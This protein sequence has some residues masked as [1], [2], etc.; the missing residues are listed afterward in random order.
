M[1]I[2]KRDDVKWKVMFWRV[3][4]EKY[5]E[6]CVVVEELGKYGKLKR[7]RNGVVLFEVGYVDYY[8]INFCFVEILVF[9]DCGLEISMY[10][11]V[12]KLFGD[13]R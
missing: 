10:L 7:A 9:L 13:V 2:R 6:F 12:G 11:N 1:R 4:K 3:G 5:L 8:L